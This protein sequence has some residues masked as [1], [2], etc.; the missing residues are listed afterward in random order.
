M[1][2]ILCKAINK[3][4]GITSISLFY[5][6]FNNY[7]I[8]RLNFELLCINLFKTM[9]CLKKK[10]IYFK[11]EVCISIERYNLNWYK[12]IKIFENRILINVLT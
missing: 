5:V 12:N 9:F 11:K 8:T 1:Y 10:V 7:Q 2:D 6:Q 3:I 4:L